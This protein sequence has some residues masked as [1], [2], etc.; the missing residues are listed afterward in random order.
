[1]LVREFGNV[2]DESVFTFEYTIKTIAELV[3]MEDL[4]LCT[5]K[6]IPFQA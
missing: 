6:Y 4:D 3:E 2:T 1:M 5:L